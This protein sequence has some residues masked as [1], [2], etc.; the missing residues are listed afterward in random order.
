M[1]FQVTTPC[2]QANRNTW[3]SKV[4]SIPIAC[5]RGMSSHAFAQDHPSPELK[6]ATTNYIKAMRSFSGLLAQALTNG[7]MLK[8]S[9]LGFDELFSG[10]D[11]NTRMKIVRYPTRAT[12]AQRFPNGQFDVGPHKDHQMWGFLLQGPSDEAVLEVQNLAGDWIEVPRKPNALVCSLGELF[13]LATGGLFC[14]TTHR[15]RMSSRQPR[16]SVNFF[17]GPRLDYVQN[18]PLLAHLRGHK[19]EMGI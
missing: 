14:A 12:C 2:R 11:A 13:E 7:L 19:A 4:I 15:V 6:K 17:I 10:P 9:G 16:L 3:S 1:T 5:A 8:N 18:S